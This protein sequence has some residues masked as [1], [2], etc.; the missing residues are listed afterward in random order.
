[1]IHL[2]PISTVGILHKVPTRLYFLWFRLKAN[3]RSSEQPNESQLKVKWQ[4]NLKSFNCVSV[5][6]MAHNGL[7]PTIVWHISLEIV[8]RIPAFSTGQTKCGSCWEVISFRKLP[9]KSCKLCKT[10]FFTLNMG[11]RSTVLK[12]TTSG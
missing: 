11:L 8:D 9:Q 1:M 3:E 12:R 5:F 4:L 7:A 2:S 6:E 10:F